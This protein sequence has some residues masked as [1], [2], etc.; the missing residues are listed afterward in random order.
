MRI[1]I[2]DL[3]TTGFPEC[4]EKGVYPNPKHIKKYDSARIIQFGIIIA[5][6]NKKNKKFRELKR[7][8]ILVSPDGFTIENSEFHGIEHKTAV[9]QGIPFK[10]AVEQFAEELSKISLVVG[11][12]VAFDYNVL[13]SELYR[14]KL[15]DYAKELK[16][17]PQFCTCT[18]T[19]NITKIKNS[20][21]Y[22]Y[23]KLKELYKW[24]SGKKANE[25][26]LHNA[27]Y[28][29]YLTYLCFKKLIILGHFEL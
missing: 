5:R 6:Y 24:A 25:K 12:N 26:K 7:F 10:T 9:E 17:I 20:Y 18:Q 19:A 11:H 15:V 4:K 8:D 27:I 14:Y 1:L 13:L 29:T 16:V 22:K 28:D 23:P 2:F 3:E 21:G